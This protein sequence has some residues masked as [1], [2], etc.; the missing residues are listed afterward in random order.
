MKKQEIAG[1]FDFTFSKYFKMQLQDHS[2]L[3]SEKQITE[4]EKE[5][6]RRPPNAFIL[7]TQSYGNSIQQENP[8]LSNTEV[9]KILGKMWKE[10]PFEAK[11]Q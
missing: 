3:N 1:T 2:Y 6:S 7:Y 9:M 10:I 8:T 11:Y 5:I 4:Y